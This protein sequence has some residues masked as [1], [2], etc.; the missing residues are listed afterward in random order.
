MND[1]DGLLPWQQEL[2]DLIEK[3]QS[4]G[5]QFISIPRCHGK[6]LVTDFIEKEYGD[7]CERVEGGLIIH[8]EKPA[9]IKKSDARVIL[10][11]GMALG[12]GLLVYLCH[13]TGWLYSIQL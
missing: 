13:L 2:I 4:S 3:R 6:M 1:N 7:R 8:L 9:N 10:V 11:I 12:Y 5:Y